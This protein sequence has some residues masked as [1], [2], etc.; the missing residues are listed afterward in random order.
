MIHHE[1]RFSKEGGRRPVESPK[2]FA[3]LHNWINVGNI[4]VF[5]FTLSIEAWPTPLAVTV[6]ACRMQT[7]NR[8]IDVHC[9]YLE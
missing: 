1:P 8:N 4:Q 6:E 9:D 5:L 3:M 2:I 7:I